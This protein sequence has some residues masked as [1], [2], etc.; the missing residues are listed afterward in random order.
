MNLEEQFKQA[1][2]DLMKLHHKPD[3]NTL[4]QLYSYHKQA[5]KGD[6]PEKDPSG[7]FDLVGKAKFAAWA[8]QRGR[9][10]EECMKSYIELVEKLKGK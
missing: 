9:S 10:S 7:M 1:E 8:S 5:M 4:L 2:A 6:A 3:N